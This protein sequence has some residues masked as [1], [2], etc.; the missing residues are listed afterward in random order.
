M[1]ISGNMTTG[2]IQLSDEYNFTGAD[3]DGSKQMLLDFTAYFTDASG[4]LLQYTGGGAI[5]GGAVPSSIVVYYVNNYSADT[6][7]FSYRRSTSL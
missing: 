3:P 1:T 2:K 5:I 6:G 7:S 4:A